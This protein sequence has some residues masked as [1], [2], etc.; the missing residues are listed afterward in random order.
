[1]AITIAFYEE[2][3]QFYNNALRRIKPLTTGVALLRLACFLLFAWAVYQWVAGSSTWMVISLLMA[4]AFAILVRVAWRLNDRKALLE[5]LLFINNN[6]LAVLRQQ[7]NQFSDGASFL[8]HDGISGDLDI[9]GTG[10]LYHLL[11]RTTTWH[12]TRQLAAFLQEPLLEKKAIEQQQQAV[13]ALAPQHEL[14]QLLTAHGLLNQ[15][16]E[17]NLHNIA[18]WLQMPAIIHGKMPINILRMLSSLYSAVFLLVYLFT[19]NYVLL[20]PVVFL[21]WGVISIYAK[22]IQEQHTMLGK[23]QSIFQQYATI[24]SLFSKVETGRSSL[25]EKEKAMAAA[26]F[27]SVKQLSRLSAMFDQRLNLIVNI[28]LNSFFMY[29]IQ[30]LWSLE[31]WKKE[32]KDHFNDWIHCV[33]MI[34]SLNALATFAYNY[35]QY[36]YPVV[37]TSGVSVAATQLAHP[38][39]AAEERV[40]NDCTFGV[41]EKLVLLTG[42]NMSGKTT[43]LRTLGVNLLLA[44]SGAPV[45]AASFAFTP[46]VI[47]S[48]IRVSDSLQEHTSYFMAELKRLQQIIH[49]LQ[50]QTAPVLILIDEILRGTN[51]EDKTHGSEQFIK[52]LLQYNCLTLFATHDLALSRLEE[53]LRGK[54]NNYC[55]ESIIRDGELLFDYTLQRGVAKN[56]NASFLMAK[57]EII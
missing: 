43:F 30:C 23:K 14:R 1:M 22:R 31:S 57:M 39:I 49:Y 37:N 10:S 46:M 21:N 12:G 7:A 54:V 8:A 40:A 13:Q 42:S 3:V 15:E 24:L 25:L 56:R 34:E 6:E 19:G 28:F 47:R 5:K 41:E 55:F 52:K 50:Q 38:L 53:E 51:S 44:Q 18:D 20:I 9:F 2:K 48:S 26:A 29:D 32:H 45:C 27:G 33:G 35:P 16:K 36:R 11:N 4:A 17:G